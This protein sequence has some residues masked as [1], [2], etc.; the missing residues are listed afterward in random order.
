M[1]QHIITLCAKYHIDR[2]AWP[3]NKAIARDLIITTKSKILQWN[4]NRRDWF[5]DSVH[6]L[7]DVTFGASQGLDSKGHALLSM[8]RPHGIGFL[9]DMRRLIVS[10]SR[11]QGSRGLAI[12]KDKYH[13]HATSSSCL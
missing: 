1:Q 4:C 3:G 11:S 8:G 5:L 6:I 12:T 7:W 10:L 2:E 13:G 9:S